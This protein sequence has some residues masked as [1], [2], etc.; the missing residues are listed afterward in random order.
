MLSKWLFYEEGKGE[1]KKPHISRIISTKS[2]MG[3]SGPA[4]IGLEK[5]LTYLIKRVILS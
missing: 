3:N 4:A 5:K 1:I 2:D